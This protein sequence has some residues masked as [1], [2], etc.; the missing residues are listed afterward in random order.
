MHSIH[1][2]EDIEF[3]LY[4]INYSEAQIWTRVAFYNAYSYCK[5]FLSLKVCNTLY[6]IFVVLPTLIT[7][8][9]KKFLENCL[10]SG[11]AA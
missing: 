2:G 9:S 4:K 7:V 8:S 10:M 5:L 3:V 11:D 6:Q 1:V